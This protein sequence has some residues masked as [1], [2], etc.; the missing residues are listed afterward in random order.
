MTFC[1]NCGTQVQ[2]SVKFCSACG[3]AVGETGSV[4][5]M[6][7]SV[8]LSNIYQLARRARKENNISKAAQYYEQILMECTEDWEAV[9]FAAYYTNILNFHEGE[10]GEVIVKLNNCLDEVFNLIRDRVDEDNQEMAAT[11][12]Y[13]YM[14]AACEEIYACVEAECS[15]ISDEL[16]IRANRVSSYEPSKEKSEMLKEIL[17]ATKE[18]YKQLGFRKL[19]ISRIYLTISIKIGEMFGEYGEIGKLGEAM[20]WKKATLLIP[21]YDGAGKCLSKNEYNQISDEYLSRW[22]NAKRAGTERRV[23]KYWE[24]HAEEKAE[25]ES[26]KESLKNKV[27]ALEVEL[28]EIPPTIE[29]HFYMLELHKKIAFLNARKNSYGMFKKTNEKNAVQT[30]IN[31]ANAEIAPIQARIDAATEEIRNRISPLS[32]RIEE[33]DCEL[34]R[35]R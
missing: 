33:I 8:K 24:N 32:T 22:Q 19:G 1:S 12:V 18:N 6:D 3:N 16:T 21:H 31:E 9:F 10:R 28:E 29:G 35:P 26:E 20:F 13:E 14:V 17:N 23:N 25:F 30:K 4:A 34:T 5:D 27:A 7:N 15:G 11:E 2:D